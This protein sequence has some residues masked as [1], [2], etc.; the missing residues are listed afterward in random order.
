MAAASRKPNYRLKHALMGHEKGPISVK[1][2]PRGAWLA[3]TSAD[4]TIRIWDPHTGKHIRTLKEHEKVTALSQTA[5]L[6]G[7]IREHVLCLCGF[8]SYLH[9]CFMVGSDAL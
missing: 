9:F 7:N 6:L 8:A 3:S 2:S 5:L 4:C 1:F